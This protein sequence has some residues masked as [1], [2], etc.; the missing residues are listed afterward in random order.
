MLDIKVVKL[1]FNAKCNGF[2]SYAIA[3]DLY[4]SSNNQLL[5][6][7][8]NDLAAQRKTEKLNKE[9]LAEVDSISPKHSKIKK[10]LSEGADINAKGTFNKTPLIISLERRNN[11]L[12]KLLIDNG[13]NLNLAAGSLGETPLL[14]AISNREDGI[15]LMLLD[16]GADPN[17]SSRGS[18]K[19][20]IIELIKAGDSYKSFDIMLNKVV[21]INA[22][23]N[24]YNETALHY[25]AAAYDTYYL[26]RLLEKGANIEAKNN[27]GLTPLHMAVRASRPDNVYM[28]INNGS[29]VETKDSNGCTPLCIAAKSRRNAIKAINA[30]ISKG[31]IID[32][33]DN[34]GN[35]PLSHASK[36]GKKVHAEMLIVNS[37]D[38]N[39][40]NKS[41]QTPLFL[42]VS[43]GYFDVVELLVS[44]GADVNCKDNEG[45]TLIDVAT[46]NNNSELIDYLR[47][48]TWRSQE[49]K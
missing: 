24:H 43:G 18:R 23:T 10:L 46:K 38:I 17:I 35:S 44:R 1:L 29:D 49:L 41:G 47:G 20:P 16:K 26:K 31:A 25:A 48:R 3:K 33:T 5:L 36:A 40:R 12:I 7:G 8:R 34:K 13:A 9:L 11:K 19:H 30:L 15:T 14:I 37:A 27:R 4:N 32:N 42:A 28:L 6:T 22:A 2:V 21:D 39:I 45:L